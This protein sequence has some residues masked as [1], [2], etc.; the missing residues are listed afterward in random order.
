[1][2]F[3]E[4]NKW[5]NERACDGCWGFVTAAS[6]IAIVDELN[7]VPFWKR[8]KIWKRDYENSIVNNVVIPINNK[9]KEVLEND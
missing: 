5:C 7:K 8:E 1:M 4:F 9:M 2:T 3:K 6:C